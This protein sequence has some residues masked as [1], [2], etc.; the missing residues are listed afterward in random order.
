MEQNTVQGHNLSIGCRDILTDILRQGAQEMLASEA[1][2]MK[3]L[4]QPAKRFLIIVSAVSD[5]S[6]RAGSQS[7]HSPA[8]PSQK[9]LIHNI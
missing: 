9:N 7:A 3:R 6:R 4:K 8:T 2:L 5:Q 1:G